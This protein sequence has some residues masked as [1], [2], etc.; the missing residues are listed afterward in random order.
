MPGWTRRSGSLAVALILHA[1]R[2]RHRRAYLVAAGSI[3]GLAMLA[4]L[5]AVLVLPVIV[6]LLLTA[7]KVP[8]LTA[9]YLREHAREEDTPVGGIFLVVLIVVVASIVSLFLAL[10]GGQ[11]PDPWQV[12]ASVASV[13][14]GWFTVQ[15]MSKL[16]VHE[17]VHQP[18]A[19]PGR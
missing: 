5:T 15:A 18:G 4:K 7:L 2:S 6:F 10:S 1:S 11:E 19:P 3:F 17:A 12:L 13:L 16:W 9:D 8:H 14:L